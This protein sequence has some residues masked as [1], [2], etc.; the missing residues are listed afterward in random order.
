MITTDRCE[1]CGCTVRSDERNC[2]GCG[3][4]N[5]NYRPEDS[6]SSAD[7]VYDSAGSYTP[8]TAPRTI[9]QLRAFCEAKGMPLEKMRF[10]IGEDYRQ[11]RAF[12]IYRDG[13]NFVVYKNKGDGSRA[14]RYRGPDE[15]YAVRELYDK[16]LDECHSRGI[17]PEDPSSPHDQDAPPPQSSYGGRQKRSGNPTSTFAIAMII[18]VLFLMLIAF[19]SGGSRSYSFGSPG[20]SG[21][22][23]SSYS[24]S[25]NDSSYNSSSSWYDNDDSW[26]SS[27]SDWD[28][29]DSW[30]T[31]W[32]SDW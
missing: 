15:A 9:A 24:Y 10:F 3:A 14:V 27:S 16:L 12:G 19:T 11:P 31:D 25:Y 28:S 4:E 26:S 23:S 5:P 1:Y 22:G 30:D 21:I 29:W 20:Y 17:Y 8:G 6:V 18:F 32:D 13:N 2:P 7:P